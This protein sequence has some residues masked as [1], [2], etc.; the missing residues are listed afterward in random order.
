MACIPIVAD[1]PAHSSV[2][3]IRSLNKAFARG[4]S[5]AP[6]R[7]SAL[8][9]VNLDLSSGEVLGVVGAAGAG[10]TT[11][12]Q[13][14]AGILRRDRGFIEWFGEPF[15]GGGCLPDLAYVAPM[16]VYYPFLTVR[17]VL[18]YRIARDD[19]PFSLRNDSIASALARLELEDISAAYVCDLPREAVKRLAVA[20]A[21]AAE[22]RVIFLDSTAS[23][24][25]SP[26]APVVLRA[27]AREASNGRAVIVAVRD[28]GVIAPIASRILL[29]EKGRNV[30]TFSN[31]EHRPLAAMDPPFAVIANRARFVAERLH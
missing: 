21:L 17:D 11:L 4:P 30:G 8:V 29:L 15:A 16:P 26:C 13:C 25:A 18:E 2:L 10:K 7:T 23:D 27:L 12:L 28:A 5:S 22:P 19:L 1:N 6:S 14:A 24:I 9:D 3:R 31:E 20:E